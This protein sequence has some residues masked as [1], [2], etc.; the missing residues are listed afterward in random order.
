MAE[1]ATKKSKRPARRSVSKRTRESDS[2][3]QSSSRI[4][5]LERDCDRLRTQLEE[6]QER[7]ARLEEGRSETVNRIDWVLDSLHNVL[8]KGA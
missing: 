5:A 3:E 7:I 2:S 1:R 8:E 4:K 6:A